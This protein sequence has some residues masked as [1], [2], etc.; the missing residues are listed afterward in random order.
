MLSRR[1]LLP[2]MS[3]RHWMIKTNL[4]P[5]RGHSLNYD[6]KTAWTGVRNFQARSNLAA[7]RRGDHALFYHSAT[8]KAVVGI[9]SVLRKAY[10]DPTSTDERWVTSHGAVLEGARFA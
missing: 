8:E 2:V 3:A 5:I 1:I 9:A 6:G 4:V 7:M 10:P